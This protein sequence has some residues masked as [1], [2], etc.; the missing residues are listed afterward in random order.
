MVH[1]M[2][3]TG[4]PHIKCEVALSAV[5]WIPTGMYKYTV[6]SFPLILGL[7]HPYHS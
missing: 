5:P 4:R 3:V 7:M 1:L 2:T 6:G